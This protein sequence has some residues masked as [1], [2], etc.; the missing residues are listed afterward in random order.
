[1]TRSRD[2]LSADRMTHVIVHSKGQMTRPVLSMYGIKQTGRI[3]DSGNATTVIVKI[4]HHRWQDKE[5]P[6]GFFTQPDSEH[7]SAVIANP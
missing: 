6:S 3:D 2:A 4:S 5:I 7:I 1:V